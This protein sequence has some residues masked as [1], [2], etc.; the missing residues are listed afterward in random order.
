MWKKNAPTSPAPGLSPR[1]HPR[2]PSGRVTAPGQTTIGPSI[3]IRGDIRGDGDLL[4]EG[5]VEGAIELRQS[6]VTIGSGARVEAD[7]HGKRIC[8][9]GEVLGDLYGEEV[10]IR[11]SGRVTGNANAARVTLEN[12][13]SFRGAI[14]MQTGG[15]KDAAPAGRPPSTGGSPAPGPPGVA[16]PA[17][18]DSARSKVPDGSA[19]S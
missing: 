1:S 16:P 19:G 15:K 12:G 3:S 10:V 5:R 13:C 18:E 6:T 9:D 11:E 7:I 8:I 17:R 14:D 2:T 4:I